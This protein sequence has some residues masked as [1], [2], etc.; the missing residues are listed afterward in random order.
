MEKRYLD[1]ETLKKFISDNRLNETVKN[2]IFQLN[3][4]LDKNQ[5]HI[6]FE[7][8]R[9]LSDA[10]IINSGKLNGLEHDKIIGILNREEQRITT[11]EVQ[12][13]VLTIIDKLPEQFWDTKYSGVELS[14][15]SK[16]IEGVELL[17]KHGTQF[18]YDIFICFSTKDRTIIKPIYEQLRGYGLIVFVSYE[19]LYNVVGNNFLNDIYSSLQLSQH[20]IFFA[21][22]N[23]MNSIHVEDEYQAFYNNYHVKDPKNRF[24]FVY[25]LNNCNIEELPDFLKNKQIANKPEHIIK[26]FVHGSL[27]GKNTIIKE[28]DEEIKS[29]NEINDNS[30]FNLTVD[31]ST[32]KKSETQNELLQQYKTNQEYGYVERSEK[33]KRKVSI[34]KKIQMSIVVILLT[35]MIL[36]FVF[37]IRS[38]YPWWSILLSGLSAT[39]SVFFAFF[40]F[41]DLIGD[42]DIIIDDWLVIGK[43]EANFVYLTH[44][45][46]LTYIIIYFVSQ[47]SWSVFVTLF[48][49]LLCVFIYFLLTYLGVW[50]KDY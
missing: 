27:S 37:L 50:F 7:P 1:K 13:A 47:N 49:P 17:H 38:D 44:F 14:Y 10:L 39:I 45:S 18:K 34:H 25:L 41:V 28:V 46:I 20:L 23:S 3:E 48:S 2:L 11:A 43:S 31:N 5:T 32:Q 26:K 9:K 36:P 15:K 12:S 8:I 16:L 35:A 40:I 24:L 22:K 21:S 29:S 33:E 30:E 6:D 42:S 4:F 19:E